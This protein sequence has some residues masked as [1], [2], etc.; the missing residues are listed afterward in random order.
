MRLSKAKKWACYFLLSLSPTLAIG[1]VVIVDLSHIGPNSPKKPAHNEAL[2]VTE[3]AENGANEL[4]YKCRKI[5]KLTHEIDSTQVAYSTHL[6][7][8][9]LIHGFY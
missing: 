7:R 2:G 1:G 6:I 3:A 5:P 8:C 9:E 4:Q